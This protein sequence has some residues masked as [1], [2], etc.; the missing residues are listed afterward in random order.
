MTVWERFWAKVNKTEGCWLWTGAKQGKYGAL[1]IPGRREPLR[2][3]RLSWELHNGPI[4]DGLW[5]L[6]HCDNPPCV[7]PEHL[8][9]GDRRDNMLDAAAKGRICTIGKARLTHCQRGHPLE[10]TAY[11]D[12]K[13]HRRCRTCNNIT[14]KSRRKPRGQCSSCGFRFQMRADGTVQQHWLYSG[15]EKLLCPGGCKPIRARGERAKGE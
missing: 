7:K 3:H 8:F 10:E 4:P 5:V 2:A 6:H 12:P 11:R 15:A 1:T 9:L 14:A 13:G